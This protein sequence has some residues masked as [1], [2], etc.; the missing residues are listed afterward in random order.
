MPQLLAKIPLAPCPKVARAST[1]AYCMLLS[2]AVLPKKLCQCKETLSRKP[3]PARA[4]II[5][6]ASNAQD[7]PC[8]AQIDITTAINVQLAIEITSIALAIAI[9][10]TLNA[11]VLISRVVNII[12]GLFCLVFSI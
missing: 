10:A 4:S 2:T 7:I 11:I 1:V 8:T 3:K 12:A 9:V 5:T 6:K